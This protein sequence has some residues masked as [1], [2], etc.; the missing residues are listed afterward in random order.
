MQL[1]ADE[2]VVRR[3][4]GSIS[5]EAVRRTLK[6]RAQTMASGALVHP[7][8]KS[9]FRGLHGGRARSV[10][11]AIRSGSPSSW[12]RRATAAAAGGDAHAAT[13]GART[14]PSGRLRVPPQRDG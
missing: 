7:G 10:R 14:S 4:V 12:L 9:G 6:K 8:D 11:R 13:G 5:D 1:L 2:L 3:V